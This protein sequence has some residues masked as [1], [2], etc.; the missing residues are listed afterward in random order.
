MDR[1]L[2]FSFRPCTKLYKL[3]E[4]RATFALYV[5]NCYLSFFNSLVNRKNTDFFA[6]VYCCPN[7]LYRKGTF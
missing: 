4:Y 5:V 6:N 1:I 2:L 7:G 3:N